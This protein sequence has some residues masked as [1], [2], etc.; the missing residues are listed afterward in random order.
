[1]FGKKKDKVK[2]IEITDKSFN[3]LIETDKGILLD[4]Y[5]AWCGPCKVMGPI[6][7]ELSVKY[8]DQA[9]I[10]KVDTEINH[11]LSGF[12]K[13]KSIPTLVFIKDKKVI[14]VINGLV[15]KPN[16]EEMIEDLIKFEFAEEEE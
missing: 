6:I 16:L 2:A 14:E 11:E 12:F 3:E 9:I 4:F 15:P 5:A 1:M 13:I 8:K 10:G 7:D